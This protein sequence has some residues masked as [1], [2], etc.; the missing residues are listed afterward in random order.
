MVDTDYTGLQGCN[1]ASNNPGLSLDGTMVDFESFCTD[2]VPPSMTAS[3]T[4]VYARRM[5]PSP[6]V[7][8]VPDPAPQLVSMNDTGTGA[9]N[10]NAQICPGTDPPYCGS[11]TNPG[12]TMSADG[13]AITFFSGSSDIAPVPNPPPPNFGTVNVFVRYPDAPGGGK[14]VN[15]T[16]NVLGQ[17]GDGDSSDPVISADGGSVA[18]VSLADDLIG[19]G[20]DTNNADDVFESDIHNSFSM[21]PVTVVNENDGNATITVTRSG[22]DGTSDSVEVTSG[23]GST[24][25]LPTLP[26]QITNPANSNA[27]APGDYTAIDKTLTFPPGATTKTFTVPI[28][29]EH[30]T[31]DS[32]LFHVSLSSSTGAGASLLPGPASEAYVVILYNDGAPQGWSVSTDQQPPASAQVGDTVTVQAKITVGAG[33]SGLS[34]ASL[35]SGAGTSGLDQV[36]FADPTPFTVPAGTSQDVTATARVVAVPGTAGTKLEVA[37]DGTLGTTES[38]QST[39]SNVIASTDAVTATLSGAPA[40]VGLSGQITYQLNLANGSDTAAQVDV[41]AGGFVV[42]TGSTLVSQVAGATVVAAHSSTDYQLTVAVAG[43]DA[44]GATI[45]QAPSGVSYGMSAV[46]L[47]NRPVPVTPETSTVQAPVLSVS[48]HTLT[49]VHGGALEPN[50]AVAVSETVTNTGSASAA[51]TVTD[52]LTNL[53]SPTSIEVDGVACGACTSTG[54]SVTAPVGTLAAGGSHVLT[55]TA[56]VPASPVGTTASS[57]AVVTFLP[58]DDWHVAHGRRCGQSDY[59]LVELAELAAGHNPAAAGVGRGG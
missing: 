1:Q 42:P 25:A 55:F 22:N 37:V 36:A 15:L 12:V 54:S 49:N 45:A 35:A 2:I 14:T 47:A 7:P 57:S 13:T 30:V 26:P 51:A 43:T 23:D 4:Q 33:P 21:S 46:A 27:V 10:G 59:W 34:V 31:Q 48:A 19:I 50:D 40:T 32:K 8:A 58:G 3:G 52:T 41:P 20:S 38:V 53:A 9:G 17:N 16:A 29:D 24:P 5:A 11:S 6:S 44:D 56:T 28:V 39:D 18:F